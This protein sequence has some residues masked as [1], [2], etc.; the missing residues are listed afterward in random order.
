MMLAD[1]LV[2][3]HVRRSRKRA[4]YRRRRFVP[5]AIRV[6]PSAGNPMHADVR[7]YLDYWRTMGYREAGV[8][9]RQKALKRFVA[10]ADAQGLESAGDF[11]IELLERYQRDL[12]LYRKADGTALA[13]NSQQLLLVPLK[14]FFKW[15]ARSR[16]IQVNPAAELALPRRPVRLPARVLTVSEVECLIHQADTETPWGVRDRAILEILYSTGIRRSELAA[17]AVFDWNRT[18]EALA[19]RQGKGGRDRVVPVGLRAASW[20]ERYFDT[21]RPGLARKHDDGTMFLTDY[22]EPF[23]KNRLGDLV[24]RYLDWAG[25]RVPGACHLLR[26]ACA[27]HMLENGADIRYIQALLGHADLRSTQ[28]YTQ[29]SIVRL[30]EV[31]AAT[32]PASL[33]HSGESARGAEPIRFDTKQADGVLRSVSD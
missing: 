13:M 31:H 33:A 24:R 26:H 27:T 4:Y 2:S 18:R 30:K 8:L 10:W 15:L 20:L 12:F 3:R 28:I 17:L 16:R 29:V 7:A 9:L 19:I 1:K 5:R 6:D 22:A 23:A 11:D 21:V 14:G 32:H 25:I